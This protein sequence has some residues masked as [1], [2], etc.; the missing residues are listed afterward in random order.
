MNRC[1]W[2]EAND[3]ET[4]QF[5]LHLI[6]LSIFFLHTFCPQRVWTASSEQCCPYF[7]FISP[8]EMSHGDLYGRTGGNGGEKKGNEKRR[9]IEFFLHSVQ[10]QLWLENNLL[11]YIDWNLWALFSSVERTKI[12]A[13]LLTK[14]QTLF[15]LYHV[16]H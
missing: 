8:G 5:S 1:S 9:L 15:G 2:E 10:A 12:G 14:F 11:K 6:R 3:E 4:A 16:L 13:L 7:H